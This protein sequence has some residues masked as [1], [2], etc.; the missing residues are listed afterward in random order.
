MVKR[1]MSPF[2]R[3]RNVLSM[4]TE[5]PRGPLAFFLVLLCLLPLGVLTATSVALADSAVRQDVRERVE[6]TAAVSGVLIEEQL[7]SLAEL[8][9]SY[10]R[11][12]EIRTVLAAG[13]KPDAARY[14][15]ELKAMRTGVAGVILASVDGRLIAAE[16]STGLVQ[17]VSS[18]DWYQVA[19]NRPGGYIS[20]AFTPTMPGVS[21]S[22]AVASQITDPAGERVLGVMAV[23]YR[24][25][26]VQELASH[27]AQVQNTMLLIT[28]QT[29]VLVADPTRRVIALTSLR[30]DPRV[31][32]ALEGRSLFGEARSYGV[33]VL[34]ASQPV[35]GSN[36]TVTAEVPKAMALAEAGQLRL[37]IL[38]LSA[39]LAAALL[40]VLLLLFAKSRTRQRA[41]QAL[42]S[43]AAELKLAHDEAIRASTA[44]S[45]FLAKAS[46]E[47]RT[48]INGVLGMNELLLGTDLD[49]EQQ[50]YAHTIRASVRNLVRL[51]DDFLDLSKIEVGRIEVESAAFDL[52]ELCVNVL[53]PLRGRAEERG[54]RLSARL[55]PVL[56]RL[57]LGDEA[58]LRQV[59][60]NLLDNALKFTGAGSVRLEA[61]V[62]SR[63]DT[64]AEIR[65]TVSD[66]G[67]GIAD[68]DLEL[69]FEM[70]QT[71]PDA[72]GSGLGLAISRQLVQLM[73][74]RLEVRSLL[75]AGSR[76]GFSLRFPVLSWLPPD[77][78]PAA[79]RPVRAAP[80]SV[81]LVDDDEVSLRVAE[82]MLAKAGHE[83]TAV[84]D[85][86][87]ALALCDTGEFDLILIDC[88]LPGDDGTDIARELR[89][90]GHTV[91]IVAM[92]AAAMPDDRRR[93][94]D[95]GMNDYLTK[96]IDWSSVLGRIPEWT[97]PAPDPFAGISPGEREEILRLF[98]ESAGEVFL[99][100]EEAV[101]TGENA[102]AARLAH[103]LKGSCATIGA[104]AAAAVCARLEQY[105][106]AGSPFPRGL[107]KELSDHLDRSA[108]GYWNNSR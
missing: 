30:E 2:R 71:S 83:V 73:G 7:G 4:R 94:L 41:Q 33:A 11:R 46:H 8:V 3:S 85:G 93:C 45:L 57:V 25:D 54:L 21:R 5:L 82:L 15:A 48:P 68:A 16:P 51:L 34:S 99:R 86:E 81:L 87:S 62:T 37:R 101:R 76:F 67:P 79:G 13:G 44:K 52:P 102:E 105:A 22:I 103:R 58:R 107:L 90:R 69:V 14:A 88:Q 78:E 64:E 59:L 104:S 26:T 98:A 75:G 77:E 39:L 36:W 6:T 63:G 55:D 92:T 108:F 17:D 47:L 61:R 60:G 27:T 35:R 80:V 70:F 29:G 84:G 20:Q 50:R 18:T 53:S 97:E 96:P 66:T 28:D 12:G 95:S 10:S 31:D 32:A 19:R 74:G 56:P 100:L 9:V 23:V 40:V 1:P 43:Q 89:R 91:P 65:F 49:A 24:L 38:S 106:T 72:P 42:A